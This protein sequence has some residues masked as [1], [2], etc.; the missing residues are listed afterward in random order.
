M[1][2]FV[3]PD[4]APRSLAERFEAA[5]APYSAMVYRHCL[6]M[7]HRRED[8]E[9]A[10]QEA[11]LRAFRAYEHHQGE[12]VAAWLYTIAHHVCLDVLKSA[13]ARYETD[14]LDDERKPAEFADSSPTP[15]QLHFEKDE[16]EALWRLIQ[17]LPEKQQVLL[18]LY[19]GEGLNYEEIAVAVGIRM[20][21][22]K[23]RISRAKEQLRK[24]LAAGGENK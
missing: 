1:F 6:R 17:A 23:S 24:M 15:E 14:S 4:D 16:K 18:C 13:K 10:A 19:Y 11:M 5:C 20:G 3:L 21:T 7:L 9:D 12:G 8:A 22:I 2:V